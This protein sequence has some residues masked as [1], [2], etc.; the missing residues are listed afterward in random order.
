MGQFL[1][2]LFFGPLII[3]MLVGAVRFIGICILYF[4][5]VIRQLFQPDRK[6]YSVKELWNADFNKK[7][8][9]MMSAEKS[10]QIIAGL[11]FSGICLFVILY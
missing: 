1:T 2:E 9:V 3:N 11:C 4:W 5:G 10:G 6:L 7:D 8:P